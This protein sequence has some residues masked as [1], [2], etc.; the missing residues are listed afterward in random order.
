LHPGM[1]SAGRKGRTLILRGMVV[2]ALLVVAAV[3]AALLQG[4]SLDSLAATRFRWVPL[5]VTGLAVQIVFEIWDPEGLT[6]TGA[7]TVILASYAAVAGFTLLNRNLPGMLIATAAVALNVL[8][9]AA[10]GAMPVSPDA[11]RRAGVGLPETSVKHVVLDDDTRLP[12][13]ADV[14]PLP[15][16]REVISIGDVLLALGLARLA[17]VRTRRPRVR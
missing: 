10:N 2:V 9:I 14:I 4:G 13:L 5:L 15:G 6:R 3:I 12:W 17:Y 8:V 1:V 16:M 11:A 7:T